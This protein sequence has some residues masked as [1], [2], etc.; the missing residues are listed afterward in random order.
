MAKS[1]KQKAKVSPK[2]K[3]NT[4]KRKKAIENNIKIIKSPKRK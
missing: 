2:N 1:R 3:K 4:D